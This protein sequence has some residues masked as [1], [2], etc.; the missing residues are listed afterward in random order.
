[1]NHSFLCFRLAAPLPVTLEGDALYAEMNVI[2]GN[3]VSL[4]DMY[5]DL[6]LEVAEGDATVEDVME[7]LGKYYCNGAVKQLLYPQPQAEAAKQRQTP[8]VA[9]LWGGVE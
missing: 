5:Y 2:T 9:G 4:A 3:A 7:F 1:M 8:M 6:L